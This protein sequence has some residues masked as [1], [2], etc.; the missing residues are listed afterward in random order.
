MLSSTTPH[1]DCPGGGAQI[2]TIIKYGRRQ[3]GRQQHGCY[4]VSR[5]LFVAWGDLAG[6]G[7]SFLAGARIGV[8]SR[9]CL[10]PPLPEAP[11]LEATP[12][13]G[14]RSRRV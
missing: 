10:Q 13:E 11:Q 4:G 6:F 3:D 2:G 8:G 5:R 12:P 1:F 7:D 14:R 9:V